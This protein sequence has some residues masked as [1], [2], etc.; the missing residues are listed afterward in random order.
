MAYV[1]QLVPEVLQ[2]SYLS[3]F[4]KFNYTHNT[5]LYL[6]TIADVATYTPS[7][8]I[9]FHYTI[10]DHPLL[11]SSTQYPLECLVP[12]H[13]HSMRLRPIERYFS[14]EDTMLSITKL[15]TTTDQSM[16]SSRWTGRLGSQCLSSATPSSTSRTDGNLRGS[17]LGHLVRLKGPSD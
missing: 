13:T 10:L 7:I 17:L 9:S 12:Q 15:T 5:S 8:T 14:L 4:C 11:S 3:F 16:H 6:L 2:V 1:D